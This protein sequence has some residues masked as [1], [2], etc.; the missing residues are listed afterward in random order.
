MRRTTLA[1]LALLAA[2]AP[3]A[4]QRDEPRRPRLPAAADTND[5]RAYFRLGQELL[6]RR[7]R[8]A[9]DAFYWASQIEPGWAD[10]LYG[11]HVA[12]LMSDPRRLVLY[13]QGDRSTRRNPQVQRIDSLYYRALRIDPFLR[14]QFDRELIRLWVISAISGGEVGVD[15]PL[16]AFYSEQ[17]M[18]DMPP[19]ARARVLAGE[20]RLAQALA[21][22]DQAL[23]ERNRRWSE[24]VRVIRHERARM[25]ALA[26]NDSMALVEL[27]HAVEAGV[28]EEEGDELVFF[29]QSKAVL[30]HSMGRVHERSGDRDAAREAYA[31]ALLE[32]LSYYPAHV[33]MGILAMASGDTATAVHELALA[34]EAGS[35]DAAT[36]LTYATLLASLRRLPEAEAEL[37]AATELAPYYA[38]PWFLL[39]MVRD[40]RGEGDSVAAYRAFLARARRDDP[41]RAQ[42]EPIVVATTP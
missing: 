34:A 5:A 25:F 11:R 40:W 26:G 35:D 16:V 15:V 14:R 10:P 32:D 1:L 31:R 3:L 23:R 27:R 39:G 30:E 36:R 12:L 6:D 19:L 42:V 17:I 4:A 8:D 38:E 22:F 13:Y 20:G 9:A 21:A 29:Y 18:R 2:A 24:P 7:P 41:R 37:L 33:R 28:E